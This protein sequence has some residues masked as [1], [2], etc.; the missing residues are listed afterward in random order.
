M[1]WAVDKLLS[2]IETVYQKEGI[3]SYWSEEKEAVE[4]AIKAIAV[5]FGVER[6][7]PL[8]VLGVGGSG[9]VLRLRD[10]RFPTV[11]NALKFPRPVPGKVVEVAGLLSREIT[12]LAR[13]RHRNIV[14]I[15][16][17]DTVFM[18]K[19]YS[20]VPFYLMEAIDGSD[21]SR[22]LRDHSSEP[23]LTRV[24][25][26]A[27]EILFYLHSFEEGFAHLDLKPSNFVIDSSGRAVMIDLGTCKRLTGETDDKTTVACTHSY[28]H[29]ELVR[30]LAK[31]PSDENRAKGEV[32][33]SHIRPAWDLWSFG[34][35]IL[36]WLGFDLQSGQ[37]DHPEI[38]H[39]IGP[40]GGKYLVLLAA[41]LLAGPYTP[42]W[43]LKATGLSDRFLESEKVANAAELCEAVRGRNEISA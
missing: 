10:A 42:S 6:Y 36:A 18:V 1:P 38:M 4:A 32:A 9:I 14:R 20:E 28:A 26:D 29:P 30:T 15:L 5:S 41:R 40:Y 22:Y 43:L 12:Y 39:S 8:G 34:L 31:D 3:Q 27:A 33:R 17:Y 11:D 37:S 19:G 25:L 16:E 23:K 35:T 21:S 24:I 2:E 13:L 7:T